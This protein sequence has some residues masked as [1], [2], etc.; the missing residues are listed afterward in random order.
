MREWRVGGCRAARE[1]RRPETLIKTWAL[2]WIYCQTNL[3]VPRN[4]KLMRRDKVALD[5]ISRHCS[6]CVRLNFPRRDLSRQLITRSLRC[7]H[8]P[9]N[10]LARVSR[11]AKLL[12]MIV[13][14]CIV[15]GAGRWKSRFSFRPKGTRD[16]QGNGL[17]RAAGAK[18]NSDE[19]EDLS[20]LPFGL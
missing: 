2:A 8:P 1:A 12:Y 13:I 11:L 16:N 15:S 18:S 3:A 20:L 10:F 7:A 17:S 6:R 5:W 9:P 4:S 19:I 14:V